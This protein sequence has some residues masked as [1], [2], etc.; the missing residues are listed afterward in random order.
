MSATDHYVDGFVLS[1][2]RDKIEAYR[3]V[4]TRAAAVWKDHGALEY[5]E[6]IGDD[7]DVK[8]Q[9]PFPRMAGTKDDEV[10]VFSYV[11]YP[12]RAVRDAANEKIMTD[13]RIAEM[14]EE[15]RGIFDCQRMAFGGFQTMVHQ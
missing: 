6:C 10:V 5:R 14:C 4:A 9:V 8:D 3:A 2:P 11:V 15:T 1:V 7:V 13:P 12:S